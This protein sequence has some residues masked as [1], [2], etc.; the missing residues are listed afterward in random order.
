MQRRAVS[1]GP[2]SGICQLMCWTRP[3]LRVKTGPAMPDAAARPVCDMCI[4][5]LKSFFTALTNPEVE[6]VRHRRR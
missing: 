3:A 5:A 1:S 6:G 2:P 4:Q